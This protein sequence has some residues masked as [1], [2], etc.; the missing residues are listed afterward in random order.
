MATDP[1]VAAKANVPR[2][3]SN[4]SVRP[5]ALRSGNDR[6]SSQGKKRISAKLMAI[7][8]ILAIGHE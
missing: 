2:I 3:M 6:M 5:N 4:L 8:L 7:Q 1:R